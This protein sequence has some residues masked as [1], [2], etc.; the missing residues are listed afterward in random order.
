LEGSEVTVKITK[1]DVAAAERACNDADAAARKLQDQLSDAFCEKNNAY[2]RWL[3][4][5]KLYE[6]QPEEKPDPNQL[7]FDV[8]S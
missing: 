2:D 6:T 4:L 8:V 7:A 1:A 3:A 5:R